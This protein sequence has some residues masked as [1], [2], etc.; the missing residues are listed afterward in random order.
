MLANLGLLKACADRGIQAEIVDATNRIRVIQRQYQIR[1]KEQH[2]RYVSVLPY[3]DI[4]TGIT[5][6][7]F[8]YPIEHAILRKAEYQNLESTFGCS[9][10]ISNEITD[11]LAQIWVETGDLLVVESRDSD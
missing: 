4:V 11:E 9:R 3:S 6:T 8:R 2:G 7:G 1:K 10:G 5:M